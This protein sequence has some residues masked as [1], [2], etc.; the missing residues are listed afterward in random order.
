M[1]LLLTQ[2]HL[3]VLLDAPGNLGYDG[4]RAIALDALDHLKIAN[5]Q[6]K[7]SLLHTWSPISTAKGRKFTV[8]RI[9][10]NHLISE[11]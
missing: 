8:E 6:G 9:R 5:A 3:P 7:V 2:V 11:T 1:P 10:G 4:K